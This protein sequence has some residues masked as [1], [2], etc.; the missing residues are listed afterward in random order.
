MEKQGR[1]LAPGVLCFERIFN[2]SIEKVWSY[3]T[4]SE[5]RGKWL[6]K[7][8]MELFEGGKVTLHFL[9]S[10][11]SPIPGRPP[12]MHR[13]M[14]AGHSFTG[15][16]L[17]IDPPRLLTFTWQEDSEVT[18]ELTEKADGVLLVLTHRKLADTRATKVNVA[19]GWHTHLEILEANL[20]GNVPHNFWAIF[21]RVQQE[22]NPLF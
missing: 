20:H 6:A 18:F 3:L 7:G 10:D 15:K 1:I 19:S 11:L 2:S 9:H 16:I 4:D 22:Y 17:E 21:E 12:E 5:K 13:A 14:E 8:D